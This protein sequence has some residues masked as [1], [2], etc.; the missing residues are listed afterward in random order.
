M[1][2]SIEEKCNSYSF[3]FANS[4]SVSSSGVPNGREPPP[5]T[6]GA[7]EHLM[8]HGYLIF[9]RGVEIT[10]FWTYWVKEK[11]Y[12]TLFHQFV[13]IYFNVAT[14]HFR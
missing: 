11:F 10:I 8:S 5:A 13:L 3:L 4:S 2:H 14:T 12:K 7:C 6:H 1:T 9:Q